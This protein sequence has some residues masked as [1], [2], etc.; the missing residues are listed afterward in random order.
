MASN[1]QDFLVALKGECGCQGLDD[2]DEGDASAAK[3]V[4]RLL[5]LVPHDEDELLKGIAGIALH[6][7][8]SNN[9]CCL[10]VR[11]VAPLERICW[12]NY[13]ASPGADGTFS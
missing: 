5:D 9:H 4:K 12:V 1:A 7:L 10:S 11:G 8:F 13:H 3:S 6:M 2:E